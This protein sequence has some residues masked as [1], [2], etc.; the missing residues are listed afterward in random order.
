M[1][2][3]IY[4][5]D[6]NQMIN[7]KALEIRSNNNYSFVGIEKKQGK[8]YFFIPKGFSFIDYQFLSNYDEKRDLFFNFYK[9]IK[10]FKYICEEKG[11]LEKIAKDRDGTII[12]NLGSKIEIN[13]EGN[14]NI[15]YSKLDLI[16]DFLDAYDELRILALKY[17]LGKKQK[18]DVGQIHKYLHQAIYLPNNAAYVDEML[19]PRQAIQFEATDIVSM[20]CYIFVE[21]KQQLRE[22]VA[23]EIQSLSE[24]FRQKYLRSQ[25][26][27]FIEST[28]D[29]VL[30]SLKESLEIID[31]NTSIKDNDYWKYYEAIELFLYGDLTEF[32]D[33]QIWGISNFHSVWE[34]VCLTYLVKSH[35]AQSLLFVDTR[36][37]KSQVL[38][39]AGISDKALNANKAIFKVNS[40][41]LIPDAVLLISIDKQLEECNSDQLYFISSKDWNDYGYKTFSSGF[42]IGYSG[43]TGGEHTFERL[44]LFYQ[45]EYGTLTINKPLSNEFHSF[46]EIES[47]D[48]IDSKYLHKMYFFNHLFY[49]ALRKG[50]TV[51]NEFLNDILQP[52]SVSFNLR[53]NSSKG[54]V[55]THSLLREYCV[56]VR[57]ESNS[58][59]KSELLKDNFEHF[60]EKA[61]DIYKGFFEV[62]DVKY[63]TE[64]WFLDKKNIEDIKN[65]SVRKQFVYEYLLQKYLESDR[66]KSN[67]VIQSSFWLPKTPVAGNSFS[68]PGA[69]FMNGCIHLRNIDFMK[70]AQAYLE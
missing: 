29:E 5:N 60:M 36:Y 54:N 10:E 52:L 39:D 3:K 37:I 51:W 20:Y 27:I 42:R 43:Q 35:N 30:K 9:I 7:F 45:Y 68:E 11:Y 56:V 59:P 2:T 22:S 14:E 63:L 32:E 44:K 47:D 1:K 8:T 67:R 38:I 49:L 55:I 26:S 17:R 66:D 18:F 15:F 33:G 23:L 64:E 69:E 31:K 53:H 16:G 58:R 48:I 6:I 13:V 19:I 57:G 21:I 12:K 40:S 4:S 34:S 65:R 61:K 28:Y 41:S 46:W 25:D 50:I 62:I 70:I 24:K